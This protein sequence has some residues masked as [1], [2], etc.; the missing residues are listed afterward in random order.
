V[1][2]AGVMPVLINRAFGILGHGF[3]EDGGWA[4]SQS[5]Y[6]CRADFQISGKSA[7][8]AHSGLGAAAHG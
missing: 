4:G 5:N 7:G 6:S 1:A 2:G 3:G 8:A